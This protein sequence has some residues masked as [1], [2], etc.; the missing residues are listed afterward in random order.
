LTGDVGLTRLDG[1]AAQLTVGNIFPHEETAFAANAYSATVGPLVMHFTAASPFSGGRI[2]PEFP[3]PYDTLKPADGFVAAR[4]PGRELGSFEAGPLVSPI[5]EGVIAFLALTHARMRDGIMPGPG[6]TG[7]QHRDVRIRPD[8]GPYGALEYGARDTAGWHIQ[9]NMAMALLEQAHGYVMAK[10]KM[11]GD[12][13]RLAKQYPWVA[14]TDITEQHLAQAKINAAIL[15]QDLPD[16]KIIALNR[17]E[18]TPVQQWSQLIQMID[19]ET[20]GTSF[21]LPPEVT[22]ILT[23]RGYR[24]TLEQMR[25]DE[26]GFVDMGGFYEGMMGSLAHYQKALCNQLLEKMDITEPEAIAEVQFRT[27]IAFHQYLMNFNPEFDLA[28]LR[29]KPI[30]A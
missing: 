2:N 1:A 19:K 29:R 17:E 5:P 30:A 15:S 16:A 26:D 11:N 25:K 6:R 7:G 18:I 13:E 22:L 12:I 24:P 23:F 14:S 10:A 27:A 28:F 20:R 8:H 9:T 4:Y 21:G 3:E